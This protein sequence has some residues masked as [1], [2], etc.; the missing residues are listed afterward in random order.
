MSDFNQFWSLSIDLC[1][2]LISSGAYRYSYVKETQYKIS[3]KS[4][5][6]EPK[7]LY[8]RTDRRTMT[9]FIGAFRDYAKSAR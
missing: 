4:V 1:P 9:E 8:M 7:S 6:W 3:R 2:I 5:Q